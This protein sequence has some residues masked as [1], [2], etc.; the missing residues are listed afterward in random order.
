M[1]KFIIEK[2]PPLKGCI[3][4][5]GA[6]NSV[7][8]IIA[9][10]LMSDGEVTIQNIP[11]L[12]D[13]NVINEVM[14]SIGSSIEYGNGILKISTNKILTCEA[15]YELV[16]KMRASF[17][18]MGALLAKK[19]KAK[20]YTPGG[21]N[22]GIRPVDLHLKGFEALG[23]KII[24]EHGYIEAKADR[25]TGATIYLDFPSVGAT[26]NIMMAATLA[27]GQTIIENSA[28]EPEIVDLAKFLNEMGAKIKG[29][30]TDTI[31]I[32]GVD[33]LGP[34]EHIVIPDRIEIGTFMI[35]AAIT[36]GDITIH[37]VIINHIVSIIA[38]LREIGALVSTDGNSVRVIG[39][40]S[41]KATDVKTL[42]YPGFPTDMQAPFMALMS[43]AKGNSIIT[44][45]IF[46]NRFLYIEELKRMGAKIKL[47]GRSAIIEGVDN[48]TGAEV[49]ATDLRAG[50]ALVL[51]ALIAEGSTVINDIYHI[52]RG[53]ENLEEKI[54]KL[55]GKMKR[56]N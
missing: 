32:T 18:I 27:K 13:V 35:A 7:L 55:G 26:E 48:L 30:G 53:Y 22:I 21:C 42:P 5:S 4:A 19:G 28:E 41:I 51:A 15:P 56:I 34:T 3:N 54:S 52:D 17:L 45:T 20:M 16:K 43:I 2:S 6:K 14:K 38:K 47:E 10:S 49:K 29:A 40:K 50:A 33:S 44:E 24:Q 31:R 25:L 23:A 39:N 36:G 37:N 11:M 1:P 8:P 46:E 9:A 12:E